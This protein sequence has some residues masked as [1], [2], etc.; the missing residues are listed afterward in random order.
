MFIPFHPQFAQPAGLMLQVRGCN[1]QQILLWRK[2][3][4]P[5]VNWPRA[6][7]QETQARKILYQVWLM[8]YLADFH[9]PLILLF[10][11]RF[12]LFLFVL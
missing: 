12:E 2:L 6:D 9:S 11:L 4:M 3:R 8:W 5:V 1:Q 10:T 7:V